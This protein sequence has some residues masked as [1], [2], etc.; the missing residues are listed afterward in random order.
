M[1][2]GPLHNPAQGKLRVVGFISGSG[3]T[4]WQAL[5]L[6]KQ[7]EQ[8]WEGSPFE[9]VGVFSSDPEAKGVATAAEYD[10]PCAAIDI[11]AYYKERGAK[12]KDREV[13]KQYDAEAA[14]LI[15]KFRPDMVI[16]AG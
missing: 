16:L 7:L 5:E 15:A 3:K 6:Q 8:T 2:L 4:L 10:I 1:A 13:R 14:E 11:R 12:L 9:V